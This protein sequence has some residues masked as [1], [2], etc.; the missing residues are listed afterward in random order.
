MKKIFVAVLGIWMLLSTIAVALVGL[1]NSVHRATIIMALGLIIFWNILGGSIMYHFRNKIRYFVQKINIKWQVKFVLF[2]TFLFLIEEAITT[3]MT[4]LAPA[5]GVKLGEAY[6]TASAN[7]FDVIFFHSVI[8]IAPM[9][10]GWAII[11]SYFDFK[12]FTVF[13][14]FGITGT[15]AEWSFSGLSSLGAFAIWI[16]VYGLM[17]YLPAYCCVPQT[18]VVHKARWWLY[19]LAVFFPAL[20]IPLTGWIPSLFDANHPKI[21]F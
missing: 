7:Y 6:I 8:V 17:V 5:F 10:I 19:P 14:L 9:F 21:D 11:L 4:N 16:F 1:N 20:F 18:R 15:L 2:A 13:L 12:P 3:A